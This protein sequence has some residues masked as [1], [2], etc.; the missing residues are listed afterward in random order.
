MYLLRVLFL[1]CLTCF[2]AL[3][4]HAATEA[5]WQGTALPQT[6]GETPTTFTELLTTWEHRFLPPDA[7]QPPD[8]IG[9][10]LH[11]IALIFGSLGVALI[12]PRFRDKSTD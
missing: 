2:A 3:A 11:V 5:P 6:A 4:A 1:V 7:G 8:R 9:M 10:M 12:L